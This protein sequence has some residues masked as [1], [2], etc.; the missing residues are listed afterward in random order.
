MIYL[1]IIGLLLCYLLDLHLGIYNFHHYIHTYI[2]KLYLS[3]DFSVAYI[4][5]S[6]HHSFT[7]LYYFVTRCTA[8]EKLSDFLFY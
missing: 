5:T 2:H 3:S 6:L 1:K 4:A 8:T 7:A